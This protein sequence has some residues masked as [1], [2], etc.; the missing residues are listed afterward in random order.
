MGIG[1][2]RRNNFNEEF[3]EDLDKIN[4][5]LYENYSIKF[6]QKSS[7][8]LCNFSK[9]GNEKILFEIIHK[10]ENFSLLFLN[11]IN[12]IRANPLIF[13]SDSKKYSLSDFF[14]EFISNT[15]TSSTIPW[16]YVKANEIYEIMDDEKNGREEKKINKLKK[17][18]KNSFNIDVISSLIYEGEKIMDYI[19]QYLKNISKSQKEMLLIKNYDCCVVYTSSKIEEDTKDLAEIQSFRN[20][21]EYNSA[22]NKKYN[23]K[24]DIY[25]IYIFLF[26]KIN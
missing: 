1:C 12:E 25:N 6:E 7:N 13:Y 15:E 21:K 24:K 3:I 14:E 16:S 11:K 23:K 5:E 10:N 22:R 17:L 4:S 8:Y 19:W 9:D 26:K 18:N 2:C 20:L